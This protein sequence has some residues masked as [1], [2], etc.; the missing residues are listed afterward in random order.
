MVRL[1]EVINM[2]R[3]A[4]HMPGS[5]ERN[6]HEGSCATNCGSVGQTIAYILL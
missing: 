6:G 5:R 1:L 4:V 2:E 3:A